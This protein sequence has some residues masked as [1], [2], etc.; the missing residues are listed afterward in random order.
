MDPRRWARDARRA[1][2]RMPALHMG[3][4]PDAPALPVRDPWP[5]NPP[6]APGC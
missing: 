6:G 3:R 2:S 1:M 5:G 4:V